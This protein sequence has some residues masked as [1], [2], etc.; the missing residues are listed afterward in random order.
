MGT[1][2]QTSEQAVREMVASG[3]ED[4]EA[5]RFC[6]GK[7]KSCP[8]RSYYT[9]VFRGDKVAEYP[10]SKKLHLAAGKLLRWKVVG[11]KITRSNAT[12]QTATT[13]LEGRVV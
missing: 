2:K 9:K 12:K 1:L 13:R 11:E 10:V 4:V 6:Q 5:R 7:R 8:E 3:T